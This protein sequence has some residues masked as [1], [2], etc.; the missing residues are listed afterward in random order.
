MCRPI[1][2]EHPSVSLTA[3]NPRLP[4]RDMLCEIHSQVPRPMIS[5]E[6]D[7]ERGIVHVKPHGPLEASDFDML[8]SAVDPVIEERGE[9][10]GLMI[11]TESFPGWTSLGAM[12]HHVAFVRDHHRHIRKIALVT[13]ARIADVAEKLAAHF[14]QAELRHFPAGEIEAA[15]QWIGE[16]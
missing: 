3:V 12:I 9:L 14:V 13:N 4:S 10:A 8:A 15:K 2:L 1:V 6:I 16:S 11:E 7:E 5:F